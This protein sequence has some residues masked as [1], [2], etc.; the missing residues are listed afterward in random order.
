[1]E[2]IYNINDKS[3]FEMQNHIDNIEPKF[4]VGDTIVEKDIYECGSGTIKE[5]RDG[6][7]IFEDNCFIYINEQKLWEVV[8][9]IKCKQHRVQGTTPVVE[10]NWRIRMNDE[11]YITTKL[12]ECNI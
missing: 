8:N 2:K 4:K 1:M 9:N 6:K 11:R 7:Y 10:H 5:I 3:C 12:N